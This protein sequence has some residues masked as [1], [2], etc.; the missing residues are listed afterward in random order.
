MRW[1]K[2]GVCIQNPTFLGMLIGVEAFGW[3]NPKH[4]QIHV[5]SNGVFFFSILISRTN[6]GL[7][8]FPVL[9][10]SQS[11]RRYCDHFLGLSQ[12]QFVPRQHYQDLRKLNDFDPI[13]PNYTIRPLQTKLD[14]IF[15]KIKCCPANRPDF[16]IF[17]PAKVQ[18]YKKYATHLKI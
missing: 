11:D 17:C 7:C 5:T 2:Q 15:R 14:L 10:P 6:P 9:P 1:D 16:I 4:C 13:W 18:K 12:C 3:K 8:P